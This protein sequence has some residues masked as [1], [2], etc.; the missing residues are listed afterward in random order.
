MIVEVEGLLEAGVPASR[1]ELLGL[2]Y[3]E[4]TAYLTGKKT[5]QEMVDDLRRGIGRLAKRQ[6]TWFRGFAR[7][8]IDATWIGREDEDVLMDHP[9]VASV[10]PRS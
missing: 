7:R 4:V 3:R 8:G 2:E 9:W 10:D 5:R 6:R 1:L